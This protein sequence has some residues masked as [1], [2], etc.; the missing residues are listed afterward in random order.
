MS[1]NYSKHNTAARYLLWV[2]SD[3]IILNFQYNVSA[4]I[5]QFPLAELILSSDLKLGLINSGVMALRNSSF[6]AFFLSRWWGAPADR[7]LYCDQDMF[8]RV[9]RRLHT[10]DRLVHW[11]LAASPSPSSTAAAG[12]A[13]LSSA[14]PYSLFEVVSRLTALPAQ[15]ASLA[16][17]PLD[18]RD[19]NV[20]LELSEYYSA[21]AAVYA[22]HG[23]GY[24][25]L[26][27]LVP[28]LPMSELNS[29][30]PAM[31]HQRPGDNFL[32]L[33][34]E[35]SEYREAVFR[36]GWDNVQWA[37]G[38]A[39]QVPPQLGLNQSVLLGL[40]HSVYQTLTRDTL[41]ALRGRIAAAEGV[42]AAQDR[43]NSSHWRHV[44]TS[45]AAVIKAIGAVQ[46]AAHHLCDIFDHYSQHSIPPPH[47][48]AAP[49]PGS[50]DTPPTPSYSSQ[51]WVLRR[52]IFH[53][54]G[55]FEYRVQEYSQGLAPWTRARLLDR[56]R[57]RVQEC[58]EEEEEA[59]CDAIHWNQQ[60][61]TGYL[62]VLQYMIEASHDL[63]DASRDPAER[64]MVNEY[65]GHMLDSLAALVAAPARRSPLHMHALNTQYRSILLYEQWAAS[66][67]DTALLNASLVLMKASIAGF[68]GPLLLNVTHPD[69]DRPRGGEAASQSQGPSPA[70]SV[71]LVL[72]YEASMAA[73]SA[74][75]ALYLQLQ[76]IP[77][78]PIAPDSGGAGD[79][80]GQERRKGLIV[81]NTW[82]YTLRHGR[83][84]LLHWDSASLAEDP[85][86]DV[87]P[88]VHAG[89]VHMMA[90]LYY[91][92]LLSWRRWIDAAVARHYTPSP[93][94]TLQ[95]QSVPRRWDTDV[96]LMRDAIA[97]MVEE[98]RLIAARMGFL[99]TAILPEKQGV[100]PSDGASW[101]LHSHLLGPDP[102]LRLN[103]QDML[104]LRWAGAEL[105]LVLGSMREW[106]GWMDG[107]IQ[108]VLTP[109][110]PSA[111][112]PRLL[113]ASQEDE[114]EDCTPGEEDCLP[115]FLS[116]DSPSLPAGASGMDLEPAAV[117][118]EWLAAAEG[119]G[120]GLKDLIL[121]AGTIRQVDPAPGP[122]TPVE[123]EEEMSEEELREI[124]ARYA[125]R[126]LAGG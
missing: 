36:L 108:A 7:R 122:D 28:I 9:Y 90:T 44:Y 19:P 86:R 99:I 14:L 95:S 83:H 121:T 58:L 5:E 101:A 57:T 30:P 51:Q 61:Q 123:E 106:W 76:P 4:H 25:P 6:T 43:S 11:Y 27:S 85:P 105:D 100:L 91:Y 42:M 102:V 120:L 69:L 21:L 110:A 63:Q 45:I 1:T 82:T 50:P 10:V 96:G 94:S 115:Y 60:V 84:Y 59:V 114:Y 40:G 71:G 38:D 78:H 65:T 56:N 80:P 54:L 87:F 104:G 15:A 89:A 35:F 68:E 77:A 92:C 34:G 117:L 75:S 72:E 79:G 112:I 81:R 55:Q 23:R 8:D 46:R 41:S 125:G 17:L 126:P 29:R 109:P 73:Y 119:E 93:D 98:S 88:V 39:A 66:P 116:P 124:R 16:L 22:S 26:T 12:A 53:L 103:T 52:E 70:L 64:L 113:T 31:F 2:D 107:I 13:A 118:P 62:G 18:T 97:P 67:Q 49:T 74:L 48:G 111:I 37:M 33:M 20:L 47:P 32:H 24:V 3:A